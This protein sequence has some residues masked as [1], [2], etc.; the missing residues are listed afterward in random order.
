MESPTAESVFPPKNTFQNINDYINT[1]QNGM[2][3]E[4]TYIMNNFAK[5]TPYAAQALFKLTSPTAYIAE[6]ECKRPQSVQDWFPR[7]ETGTLSFAFPTDHDR[8]KGWRYC[9]KA[10][11]DGLDRPVDLAFLVKRPTNDNRPKP[12]EFRPRRGTTHVDLYV[13]PDKTDFLFRRLAGAA[14]KLRSQG[15][16]ADEMRRYILGQE[17]GSGRRH[18]LF[19]DLNSVQDHNAGELLATLSYHQLGAFEYLDSIEH[20]IAIIHGSSGSG[21]TRLAVRLAQIATEI[22]HPWML[23]APTLS[24]VS[25]VVD[26]V[27]RIWPETKCCHFEAADRD[28]EYLRR[29]LGR[30]GAL[31]T[32]NKGKTYFVDVS[33]IGE[34][35]TLKNVP[36]IICSLSDAAHPA[37]K[38]LQPK[39]IIVD[40][41]CQSTE[42]ETL[43]AWVHNVDSAA[44]I[45]LLGDLDQTPDIKSSNG[46]NDGKVANPYVP[47]LRLP[48]LK[49]LLSQGLPAYGLESGD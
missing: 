17:F 33:E 20:P 15:E 34:E 41:S 23:C 49:R 36:G 48:L 27:V 1:Q 32:D 18:G 26:Q 42:L 9:V 24:S 4:S 6:I 3:V 13:C 28:E 22:G 46:N 19:H 37:L 31:R 38:E 45:V 16:H 8:V 30:S 5:P 35:E 21:K 47:Q 14:I 10:T 43:L 39:L 25:K 44:L 40:D 7:V 11:A 2:K 12:E 29:K